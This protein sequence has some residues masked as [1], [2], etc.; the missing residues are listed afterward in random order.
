[1]GFGLLLF[2]YFIAFAFSLSKVYFFADIIGALIMMYSFTKLSEYNLYYK[3]AMWAVFVFIAACGTNA[4]AVLLKIY[5]LDSR[6]G[7]LVSTVKLF[8]ACAAHILIFLGARGISLGADDTKLASQCERQLV[9]SVI[10]YLAAAAVLLI[11]GRAGEF[12]AYM[13]I[14]L[15]VYWFVC[16]VMNLAV[17]YT[18]FGKLYPAD[19]DITKPKRSKIELFNKMSDKFDEFDDRSNAFRRESIQMANDEADRR[20]REKQ[21]KAK[22]KKKKK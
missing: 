2:G 11:G 16:F 20:V 19:E 9:M 3:S 12:G 7:L 15:L 13:N 5:E 6:I 22:N 17:I 10:Y 4:C 14:V 18:C 1:M 8:A 21:N